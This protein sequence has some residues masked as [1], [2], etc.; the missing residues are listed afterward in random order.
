MHAIAQYKLFCKRFFK[1][2]LY[3]AVTSFI[4]DMLNCKAHLKPKFLCTCLTN[5]LQTFEHW[6]SA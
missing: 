2:F 4:A 6:T 3:N 5:L 1:N